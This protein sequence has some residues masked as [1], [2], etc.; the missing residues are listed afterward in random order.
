[1][2]ISFLRGI[3]AVHGGTDTLSIFSSGMDA[4]RN[5]PEAMFRYNRN[6][7]P[8]VYKDVHF[9]QDD[10]VDAPYIFKGQYDKC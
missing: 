8:K 1:M 5:K 3:T 7:L 2:Q 10:A 9:W 4:A 6:S